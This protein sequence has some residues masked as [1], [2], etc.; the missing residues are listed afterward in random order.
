MRKSIQILL[1]GLAV[2]L[3]GCEDESVRP[4]GSVKAAV[5]NGYYGA[6]Y[7]RYAVTTE[8][9]ELSYWVQEL[10]QDYAGPR[11]GTAPAQ[12]EAAS[13]AGCA[14]PA[15]SE[16]AKVVLVEVYGGNNEL[17]LHF[18]SGK[19]VAGV[20][21][22][23]KSTGE[24]PPLDRMVKSSAA[25]QIDVLVTETER[26]VYLVL[27]AY[28]EIVWSLHL[29]EDARLDG[30]SV[31]GHEAQALA[32]VPEG[33]RK[34][35]VV[36][37]QSPQRGCMVTPQHPVTESW[38]AL[39]AMNRKHGGEGFRHNL[40]KADRNHRAFRNWL[41]PRIGAVDL[42]LTAY[43]TSHILVGP[44]PAAPI[45]YRPLSGAVIAYSPSASPVWGDEDDVA[46]TI[47]DWAE[48]GG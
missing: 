41:R 2:S 10:V 22:Y 35:V 34:A 33:L 11:V 4:Q 44:K 17:P 43:Q 31:I 40:E 5:Y 9:R 26:P 3:A 12:F 29:A 32:H 48:T 46:D 28:D 45:P 23:I 27:T 37:D 25:D 39:K 8:D 21:S 16:G 18:I 30:I 13:A 38:K 19:D 20:A 14:L 47:Y 15:P 42:S 24:R 6:V 7:K 36:F 1:L